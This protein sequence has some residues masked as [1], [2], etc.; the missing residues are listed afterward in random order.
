MPADSK[1]P[2]ID[3]SKLSFPTDSLTLAQIRRFEGTRAASARTFLDEG[4]GTLNI[5][6]ILNSE[7]VLA[8]K[9]Y[10]KALREPDPRPF[11][12]RSE[13]I[14]LINDDY[15]QLGISSGHHQTRQLIRD[16]EQAASDQANK[17][18]A[19]SR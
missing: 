3:L 11:H 10:A 1:F 19:K 16:L 8:E 17:H 18:V 2:E 12:I 9:A 5:A 6:S 7:I 13:M 15:K 4:L 14:D